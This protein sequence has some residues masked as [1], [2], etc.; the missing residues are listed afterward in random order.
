MLIVDPTSTE[1]NSPAMTA[2][3]SAEKNFEFAFF[4]STES[5]PFF[6][7]F[8]FCFSPCGNTGELKKFVGVFFAPA[9][10]LPR[11][12]DQKKKKPK[13]TKRNYAQL[14][15]QSRSSDPHYALWNHYERTRAR[16]LFFFY[17]KIVFAL[18]RRAEENRNRIPIL[19]K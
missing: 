14:H 10:L 2:R 11:R 5:S 3:K 6:F 15:A 19:K 9:P 4:F 18:E 12:A 13:K 17:K 8:P 1:E 16:G 7:L